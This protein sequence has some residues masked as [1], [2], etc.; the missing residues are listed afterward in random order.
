MSDQYYDVDIDTAQILAQLP[1]D[2]NSYDT[3]GEGFERVINIIARSCSKIKKGISKVF[4]G[5][6]NLA[7]TNRTTGARRTFQNP[8]QLGL[9]RILD[10]KVKTS[11]SQKIPALPFSKLHNL[12]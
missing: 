4:Y 3:L 7:Q 5:K 11:T 12:L 9:I 2:L 1:V 6:T 10:R 8:L